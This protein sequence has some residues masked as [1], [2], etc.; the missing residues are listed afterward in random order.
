MS[1]CAAARVSTSCFAPSVEQVYPDGTAEVT[2]DPGPLGDVLEGAVRPGHFRGMLTVVLKLLHLTAPHAAF[3]GEKDYQQ[4]TLVRRMVR[5]LDLDVY[6][7]GV[8]TVREPDGL[9]MSSRNAYLDPGE[10][11][12]A[13]ALVLTLAAGQ[14]AA[15]CRAPRRRPRGRA[16][17][18]PRRAARRRLGRLRRRPRRGPRP[19][20]GVRRG[21]AAGA[22]RASAASGSSTTPGSTS[23]GSAS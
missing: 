13:T 1:S 20:A 3:F 19:G 21:P 12:A 11:A 15:E 14:E 18:V 23:A 22:R 8:P 7:V 9:A 6:V 17:G 2:V 10:R 16:G 5:D 4:L